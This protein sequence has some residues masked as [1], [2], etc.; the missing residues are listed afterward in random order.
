MR[1]LAYIHKAF[2][3]IPNSVVSA[4]ANP[5]RDRAI[6][7]HLLAQNTLGFERLV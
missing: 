6:L 7:F 5:M 4:H 3:Y 1:I 2:K